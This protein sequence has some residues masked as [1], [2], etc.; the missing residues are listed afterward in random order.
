[1]SSTAVPLKDA[2][3]LSLG[4]SW[5]L[6]VI[7]GSDIPSEVWKFGFLTE[8]CQNNKIILKFRGQSIFKKPKFVFLASEKAK[9]GNP[10]PSRIL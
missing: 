4:E 9:P 5:V 2:C 6:A 3:R 8:K 1:M 7:F 10:A